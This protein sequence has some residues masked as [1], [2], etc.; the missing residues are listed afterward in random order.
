MHE[1]SLDNSVLYN[2]N[3]TIDSPQAKNNIYILPLI[4]PRKSNPKRQSITLIRQL[5]FHRPQIN[6]HSDIIPLKSSRSVVG[7]FQLGVF[8]AVVGVVG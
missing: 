5:I 2:F 8:L 6:D 7:S 3:S 4:Q 1:R